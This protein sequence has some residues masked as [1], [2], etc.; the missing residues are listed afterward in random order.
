MVVSSIVAL[1]NSCFFYGCFN[2]WLNIAT[3]AGTMGVL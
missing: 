2:Q 3:V 1:N